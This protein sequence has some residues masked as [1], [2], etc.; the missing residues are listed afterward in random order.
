SS[1]S[2]A[3]L[4]GVFTTPGDVPLMPVPGSPVAGTHPRY[5]GGEV[6]KLPLRPEIGFFPDLA[7]IPAE[8][9]RRAKLLV[10]NYPNSP[11]GGVATRDFYR[12][13]VGFAPTHPGGGGPDAAP[14]PPPHC[15]P[16]LSFFPV[17]GAT[18][19]AAPVPPPP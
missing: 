1:A 19:V 12:R 17:W 5:Y 8:V 14:T 2:S 18:K 6:Y 13:G 16:P 10:I 7:A 4:P 9:R 3:R 15:G 11:T